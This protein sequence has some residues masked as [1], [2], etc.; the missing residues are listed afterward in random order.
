L[1]ETV[2]TSLPLLWAKRRIELLLAKGQIAEAIA[3]A[4]ANNVVCEGAAFIAWDEAEKVAVSQHGVYQAS[5]ESGVQGLFPKR[6]RAGR[7][8]LRGAMGS[9]KAAFACV[10]DGETMELYDASPIM[11]AYSST[12]TYDPGP[13]WRSWRNEM[14]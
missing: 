11:G 4:K 13:A 2:A 6:A 9:S 3:L 8:S 5:M 7:V 1:A 12:R 14:E 10:A